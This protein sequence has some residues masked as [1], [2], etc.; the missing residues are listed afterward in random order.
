M[1][2][3]STIG[4]CGILVAPSAIGLAAEHTGFG[5]VFVALSGLLVVVFLMA[6]LARRADFEADPAPAE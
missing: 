1:S 2:V 6:G 5:P 3:A 4:Y